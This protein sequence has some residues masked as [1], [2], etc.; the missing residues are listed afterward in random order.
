VRLRR[1][2]PEKAKWRVL[3]YLAL[4]FL[5]RLDPLCRVCREARAIEGHHPYGQIGAL[6]LIFIPI[7]RP[8]HDM[9]E[10]HKR[11]AR[12]VGLILYK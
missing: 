4:Y 2:S 3:Y 12:D 7:C 11:I 10:N 1:V 6:I 5:I 8:C 9:I